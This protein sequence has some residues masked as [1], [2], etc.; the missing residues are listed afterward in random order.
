MELLV[1]LLIFALGVIMLGCCFVG[2]V[3]FCFGL[4]RSIVNKIFGGG[5]E[6]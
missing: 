1:I 4:L 6:K 5:K 3:A 2:G